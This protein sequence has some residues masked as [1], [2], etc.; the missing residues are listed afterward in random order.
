MELL[1]IIAIF[2]FL[3]RKKKICLFTIEE[4]EE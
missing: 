2:G 3:S 4:K 1:I